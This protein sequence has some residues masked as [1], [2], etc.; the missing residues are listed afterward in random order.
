[1]PGK[2]V[3]TTGQRRLLRV[4]LALAAFLV[5]N[6][7]YLASTRAMNATEALATPPH[8]LPGFYQGMILSH[9]IVGLG[10]AALAAAFAVWHLNRAWRR[11]HRASVWSGVG[12]VALTVVLAV[13]GYYILSEANS[14]A[15]RGWFYT[16]LACA[17]LVPS[18]YAAHRFVSYVK[19]E[20][21]AKLA[22]AAWMGGLFALL[23]AV[24]LSTLPQPTGGRKTASVGSERTKVAAW[25]RESDG[26]LP[27]DPF[28]PF[29]PKA[30][31]PRERAFFPAAATTTT[32][33]LL[34]AA[35]L[36]NNDLGDADARARDLREKGFVWRERIG[37]AT[38]VRCHPDIVEQWS[39][40]AH[41]FS[42]FNN[43]FYRK[44]VELLRKEENGVLR[45]KWCSS[46]HDPVVMLP[47]DMARADMDMD[48][49][50]GQAGLTCLSCH[51]IDRLH[52]RTGNGAYNVPDT[53][54]EPYL[55][56]DAKGGPGRT[57]H[58]MIVKARPAVHK[59]Q[60]LKPFFRTSELCSAC[61]KVS[62]DIPVNNYR[63][64]RGQNEFDN[65]H[66]SG[67]ALNASRTF[68]L[69]PVKKLCQDCHMPPEEAPLGDVSAKGGKVRSHRFLA[70]NTALPFVRDDADT[71][72]R[73]EAFLRDEKL[74]VDVFS[75]H[76]R[77]GEPTEESVS[78][79]DRTKPPLHPS[80]TV[81]VHV[82]VR[83][84]GV[85]HTFP[86]GTNDSN[87]GWIDFRVTDESGREVYRSGAIREDRHLDPKAHTYG[88]IFVNG[89]SERI[90]RRDPQNFRALVFSR[91]IG[92][93]TA[94]VARYAFTV[95]PDLAG[96]SLTIS[97]SLRWRKFER[98]FTE[99]VYEGKEV[100]DLPVTT[101]AE[102]S[103]VLPV[104]VRPLDGAAPPATP[105]QAA[106]SKEAKPEDWI[107][108]NDHGIGLLV[109]GDTKGAL[110]AFGAVAGMDP[111]RIDGWRNQAR[112]WIQEGNLTEAYAMLKKCEE[113]AP[114][115]AQ[116]AW[117]WAQALFREGRF[118]DAA[119]AYQRVLEFFPED[120]GA[121]FGL[122][123][124]YF[125]D[126][127]FADALTPLLKV[128][129]IDP[130]HREAHY[131]RM[132]CYKSLGRETEARE[133]EKAYVKYQIDEEAD[134]RTNE[135]RLRN[136]DVNFDSLPI[137]VHS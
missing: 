36:T 61:H 29:V 102:H 129:E 79:L 97:A 112:V 2:S 130:E 83:N 81:E 82:V 11:R 5:A 100:P 47:G 85:G 107:R 101:I 95:P 10:L 48:S 99:F 30:E 21:R 31:V 88:A 111:S 106:T 50:H 12:L 71:I 26:T 77:R 133:A 67:V 24:H 126:R 46:C 69:P 17:F 114:G 52:D 116:T 37:A 14:R 96:R 40:S 1:M 84:K 34:P 131:H 113:I 27:R 74:R 42:S 124:S 23:I 72:Q 103:V 39:R 60:M 105:L 16:H 18:L 75:I 108:F 58:D 66:D 32:L 53:E 13:S 115:D 117:F 44:S 8:P 136:P 73:T 65:W 110:Q 94:D 19:P 28:V 9:T 59:E 120:R 63:W 89:K 49:A 134:A 25:T 93:G 137:H 64:L 91:V 90:F 43:P 38:C 70:V 6:T 7:L 121:W 51:Q 22:G 56:K 123:Q 62:L 127:K 128:L 55:F 135:F 35:V 118:E 33:G 45:S 86:G 76:R 3:L 122:G 54:P 15:N 80:E 20:P 104:D 4:V 68:Y 119:K 125:R 92:P 41:R 57:L 78:L 87:E 109:Q 98:R 132:L